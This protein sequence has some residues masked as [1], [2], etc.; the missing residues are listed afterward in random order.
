MT[1]QGLEAHPFRPDV[2]PVGGAGECRASGSLG[3]VPIKLYGY[4]T[5]DPIEVI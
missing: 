1:Q 4:T 3:N 2:E 5:F